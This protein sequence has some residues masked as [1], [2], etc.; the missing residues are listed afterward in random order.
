MERFYGLFEAAEFLDVSVQTLRRHIY[1]KKIQAIKKGK[2]WLIPESQLEKRRCTRDDK[3][4]QLVSYLNR[5]NFSAD[6]TAI[7]LKAVNE[8]F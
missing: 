7:V 1:S 6:Q 2:K 4:I 3:V 5:C 8:I